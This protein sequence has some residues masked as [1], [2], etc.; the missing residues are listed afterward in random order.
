MQRIEKRLKE[1]ENL[2]VFVSSNLTL[3]ADERRLFLPVLTSHLQTVNQFKIL[4]HTIGAS[5]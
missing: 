2:L 5:K 1:L 4:K 3:T